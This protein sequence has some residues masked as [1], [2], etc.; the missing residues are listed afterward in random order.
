MKLRSIFLMSAVVSLSMSAE[1]ITESQALVLASK[2]FGISNRAQL[3]PARVAGN[4]ELAPYYVFNRGNNQGFVI[5]SGDDELTQIVGYSDKGHFSEEQMPVSLR[6]YLGNYANYVD[7]VQRGEARG[8]MQNLQA[9]EPV[10]EPFVTSHWNQDAPF[11]DLCPYDDAAGGRTVT[12][13]VAT[14]MAQ[15]MNYWEWPKQGQGSH[16]YEYPNYPPQ[17]YWPFGRL[18]VDF[19]KSVYDWNNMIDDY[20]QGEYTDEQGS[21]VAKLMYDCGVSV[22]MYYSTSASGAADQ[23]VATALSTYFGYNC[24]FYY[25]DAYMSDEFFKLIATELDAKRPVLFAGTG[26]AGGHEF[27]IDG[28]DT[29]RFLHVNWGWSGMS[30]GYFDMNLMNPGN[31]GIGGGGGGFS[32]MQ[33]ILVMQPDETMKGSRNQM[34]LLIM[35]EKGLK[36]NSTSVKKG[37]EFKFGVVGLTNA[38]DVTFKGKIAVGLFNFETGE[39]AAVSNVESISILGYDDWTT[40]NIPFVFTDALN[41]LADGKYFVRAISKEDGAAD[42]DTWARVANDELLMVEVNGET[43]SMLADNKSVAVNS[44]ALADADKKEFFPGDEFDVNFSI[45]NNSLAHVSAQVEFVYRNVETNSVVKRTKSTVQLSELSTVNGTVGVILTK[46]AFRPGNKYS[47]GIESVKVSSEAYEIVANVK[48]LLFNVT[49]EGGVEV[50]SQQVR[51]YP[52]PTTDVVSVE[53][54]GEVL[55]IEVY[56]VDGRLVERVEGQSSVSLAGCPSGVYVLNVETAEGA[57]RHRVVKL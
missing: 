45:T 13:C 30:D 50:L 25:R 40:D 46:L 52:N 5:I 15:A 27:V 19:S 38:S 57:A 17:I 1:Q 9:A 51:V 6:N 16:S 54:A 12:G 42:G 41:D 21:A 10:V 24:K 20:V 44:M 7:R 32:E 28:Y 31:L 26:E 53:N 3:A 29:N 49:E 18:S 11:N 36:A 22:D 43:V 39:L 23:T 8:Y 33:S 14:A 34:Q 37:E 4:G 48:P 35:A 55:S 2:H 47:M 56:S